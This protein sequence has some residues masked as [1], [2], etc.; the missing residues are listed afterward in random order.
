MKLEDFWA[1][2]QGSSTATKTQR[3]RTEWLTEHLGRL[4]VPAIIEFELHLTAQRKRVDTWH[5]WGA[6]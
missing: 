2:I 3:E 1:L 5:M 4:P 6:A